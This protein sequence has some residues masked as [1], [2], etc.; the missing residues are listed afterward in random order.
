MNLAK[1]MAARNVRHIII[2]LHK[3]VGGKHSFRDTVLYQAELTLMADMMNKY[4]HWNP[5]FEVRSIPVRG[6]SADATGCALASMVK[7]KLD[8][9]AKR[10]VTVRCKT[11]T[12]LQECGQA[13]VIGLPMRQMRQRHS[14][15]WVTW[16]GNTYEGDYEG[17][18]LNGQK[19]GKGTNTW[20]NGN[21]YF[22]DFK[23][24]KMDGKG[25]LT[26]ANGDIY[27]G[28]FKNGQIEGKGTFTWA[29]GNKYY[30]DWKKDKLDGQGTI[31]LANG[32]SYEARFKDGQQMP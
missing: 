6:A 2:A 29:N 4:K 26:F 24:G 23:K 5:E 31:T 10:S 1:A 16:R 20:A 22:G 27:E 14:R 19:D 18:V 12:T 28:D 8:N 11:C 15:S 7:Q 32:V 25:T 9:L 17:E 3:A 13:N 30:G 21:K